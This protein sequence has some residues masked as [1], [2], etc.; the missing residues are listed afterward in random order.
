MPR[1]PAG[2]RYAGPT[3]NYDDM[4]TREELLHRL[5]YGN[6]A[7]LLAPYGRMDGSFWGKLTDGLSNAHAVLVKMTPH[8]I[9]ARQTAA[10]LRQGVHPD[11]FQVCVLRAPE[12]DDTWMVYIYNRVIPALMAPRAPRDAQGIIWIRAEEVARVLQVSTRRAFGLMAQTP[13]VRTR[14]VGGQRIIEMAQQ[15]LII[16]A[17]RKGRH[18]RSRSLTA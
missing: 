11:R 10:R 15:D 17:N 5:V 16:L 7:P 3:H 8:E 14:R 6:P 9:T 18:K 4:T 2:T 1:F 13:G 12:L